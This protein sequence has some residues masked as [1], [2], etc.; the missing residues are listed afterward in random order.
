LTK[1]NGEIAGKLYELSFTFCK[2][3]YSDT[4]VLAYFWIDQ[5]S[6]ILKGL[7]N[8]GNSQKANFITKVKSILSV[9]DTETLKAVSKLCAFL[10]RYNLQR[11]SEATY[12][13]DSPSRHTD[14]PLTYQNKLMTVPVV[15]YEKQHQLLDD[16]V[17]LRALLG[18]LRKWS[19]FL[20]SSASF[21][22]I[23]NINKAL[24]A[25]KAKRYSSAPM[26]VQNYNRLVNAYPDIKED[27][28]LLK[29][30]FNKEISEATRSNAK[31]SVVG[32][33]TQQ[34][35]IDANA[36][37][38]LE[39]VSR[40]AIINSARK[41]GW[42][43]KEWPSKPAEAKLGLNHHRCFVT[44]G[45]PYII[46]RD[47]VEHN[48][49][50]YKD[51]FSQKM[52][53]WGLQ[54]QE[55]GREPD[56]VLVFYH[57]NNIARQIKAKELRFVFADAKNNQ[58]DDGLN[59]IRSAI[60]EMFKY[61]FSYGHLFQGDIN[62]SESDWSSYFSLFVSQSPIELS[63]DCPVDIIGLNEL[64]DK[65]VEWWAKVSMHQEKRKT[66]S[67]TDTVKIIF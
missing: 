62:F 16:D 12:Q 13:V 30:F 22:S 58:K 64:D 2:K 8:E 14:W 24:D 63:A 55:S 51:R 29:S 27:L 7:K 23:E 65:T 47:L 1:I 43:Y 37:Y 59:Y 11:V 60:G 15:Y 18:L 40:Y 50:F 17:P 38:A 31:K 20:E 19:D 10:E 33:L 67:G 66:I 46:L 49:S 54:K 57:E 3:D 5:L 41:N 35:K 26:T 32:F 28:Y 53:N 9:K 25:F 44:K 21:G 52:H 45:I 4:S 42:S 39:L 61:M 56:I 48:N 36:D 34:F 6:Y